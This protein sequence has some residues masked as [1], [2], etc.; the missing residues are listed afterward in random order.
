MKT[1]D[2]FYLKSLILR[3]KQTGKYSCGVAEGY[4]R[5]AKTLLNAKSYYETERNLENAA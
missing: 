1:F 4:C 2:N 5:Y 3:K